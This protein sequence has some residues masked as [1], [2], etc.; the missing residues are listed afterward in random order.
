MVPVQV[1]CTCRGQGHH[2]LLEEEADQLRRSGDARR[3]LAER[4]PGRGIEPL[5]G[6]ARRGRAGQAR[7]SVSRQEAYGCRKEEARRGGCREGSPRP[8]GA[9]PRQRRT[10]A[11]EGE[12][13]PRVQRPPVAVVQ[14]RRLRQSPGLQWEQSQS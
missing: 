3:Q 8:R 11:G 14:F 2:G 1:G 6:F 12:P 4:E 9:G 7:A 5:L 10:P 13:R